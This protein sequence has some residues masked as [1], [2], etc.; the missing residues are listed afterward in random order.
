MTWRAASSSSATSS[1]LV[2]VTLP[3]GAAP[4]AGFAPASA[5]KPPSMTFKIDRFIARH[6]M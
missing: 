5:P 4:G 3:A 1:T 6:M 2:S